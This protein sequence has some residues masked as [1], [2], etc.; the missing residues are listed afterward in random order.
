M[1]AFVTGVRHLK[2]WVSDLRRSR[3]WYTAVF[4]LQ[5]TMEFE[6]S[7]GVVRGLAF[8]VPGAS[9]EFA[10]R[11]N[12][13]LAAALQDADPFALATTHD[14][15][16]AWVEKLDRLR[17]WHSPIIQASRGYAMGLRDPDGLQIRL[18]AD[19]VDVSSRTGERVRVPEAPPE[20][21]AGS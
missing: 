10:L 14:S 12:A 5:Q 20:W 18:Y 7:D 17:I 11:E 6:D 9:F 21:R 13:G 16:D 15:L 19:D 3:D 2:I 8:R 4:D 1:A